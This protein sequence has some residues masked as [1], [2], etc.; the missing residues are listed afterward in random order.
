MPSRQ[1]RRP[2]A[3][4]ERRRTRPTPPLPAPRSKKLH[5]G[6]AVQTDGGEFD[7]VGGS[8]TQALSVPVPLPVFSSDP[9]DG[10]E[11]LK[12]KK[13]TMKPLRLHEV[14]TEVLSWTPR[15]FMLHNLLT[16]EECEQVMTMSRRAPRA[17]RCT[18]ARAGGARPG[19]AAGRR[20]R[21]RNR[22]NRRHQRN[23]G[24]L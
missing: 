20:R 15:I 24:S 5:M 10:L 16:D 22:Q 1:R 6:S 18:D 19:P 3:S 21:H 11:L 13:E 8:N 4:T 17:C 12:E 2:L 23:G 9:L 14:T 7:T